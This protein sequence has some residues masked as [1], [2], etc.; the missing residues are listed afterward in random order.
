MIMAKPYKTKLSKNPKT[1]KTAKAKR[2]MLSAAALAVL[3]AG[4][5]VLVASVLP[6]QIQTGRLGQAQAHA[7]EV[8]QHSLDIGLASQAQYPSSPFTVV[9]DL[10]TVD[11]I[12]H[13]IINFSVPVDGLNEFAMLTEPAAAPPANG[14]PAIILC[15]GYVNPAEYRTTI[16]YDEDMNFY[17]KNGFAVIK[18]DF[19]GQGLSADHGQPNS[20]YYSM[21]Y[22]IDVM[23]LISSLKLTKGIDKSNL[24]LWGHS[25]GAYIALRAAVMSK[26]IKNTILL[27]E[28][29]GSIKDIYLSYVPPSDENNLIALKT[30]SDVFSNYGTPA[31]NP[32][33]WQK[34][35][36]A[37][38]LSNMVSKV[39]IH[40]GSDDVVVPP[41]LSADLDA[42]LSAAHK[43]HQYYVYD[44]VGHGLGPSRSL[45]WSRS[46]KDLQ[47]DT[48]S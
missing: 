20:A 29:G 12:K 40:V 47:A 45:I 33:F 18:P 10:G 44:G 19:R 48:N 43:T 42:A 21:D 24:N 31:E 6:R 4:A 41:K 32:G 22:N 13:Q 34:A 5:S 16:A 23:S 3:L 37:S 11:G 14:F 28:P 17:A 38:Y 7:G 39:Q 30:R 25:M 2:L 35:S 36:P 9:S 8:L 26:D 15:H 1:S 27:S 46:L